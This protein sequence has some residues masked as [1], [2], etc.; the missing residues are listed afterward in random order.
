MK[1]LPPKWARKFKEATAW[2][3]RV[4]D[5]LFRVVSQDRTMLNVK[6]GENNKLERM[7]FKKMQF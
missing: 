3:N 4:M 1:D 5:L 6:E 7:K 2:V